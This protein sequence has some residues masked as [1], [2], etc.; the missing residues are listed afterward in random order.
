MK[1]LIPYL[2]ILVLLGCQQDID[3]RGISSFE[4]YELWGFVGV[5]A[6]L[7]IN[8]NS[9]QLSY[10]YPS[11]QS[12]SGCESVLTEGEWQDLID[13]F[14]YAEFKKLPRKVE[15]DCCDQGFRGLKINIAGKIQTAE[16]QSFGTGSTKYDGFIEKL[17][18]R[19]TKQ[20]QTCR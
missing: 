20:R 13:N 16:W 4:Y 9:Q 14:D 11:F 12:K 15:L 6:T 3:P 17:N 7:K 2:L 18:Q 19:M 10:D 8:S 1:K 5:T